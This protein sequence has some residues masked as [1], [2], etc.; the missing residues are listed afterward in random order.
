[1]TR[2]TEEKD[3]RKEGREEEREE[4]AKRKK[5]QDEIS[6]KEKLLSLHGRTI[7]AYP[8]SAACWGSGNISPA[9]NRRH[10]KF[11]SNFYFYFK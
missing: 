3:K 5:R 11:F 6:G 10:C 8:V 2:K 7:Y 4:G 1:M 9:I